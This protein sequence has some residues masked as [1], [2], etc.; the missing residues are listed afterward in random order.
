LCPTGTRASR[1]AN[2]P[3]FEIIAKYRGS[4]NTLTFGKI[5]PY[6]GSLNNGST[7]QTQ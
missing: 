4:F 5:K 6:T 7:K 3:E 1:V 2:V